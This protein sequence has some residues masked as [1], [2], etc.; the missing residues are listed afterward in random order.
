MAIDVCDMHD[1]R[2]GIAYIRYGCGSSFTFFSFFLP[3]LHACCHFVNARITS[4]L[5]AFLLVFPVL[6]LV[7]PACFF[8]LF[9]IYGY[10][11]FQLLLV[12]IYNC[13]IDKDMFKEMKT[14]MTSV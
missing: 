11:D 9:L 12:I 4:W 8:V 1:T 14:L 7:A 5:W 3:N 6:G 10:T 13:R 2:T